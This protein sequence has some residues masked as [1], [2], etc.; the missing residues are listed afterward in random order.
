LRVAEQDARSDR[1]LAEVIAGSPVT[2][3]DR[4][5]LVVDERVA[6]LDR[7]RHA[8]L[9]IVAEHEVTDRVQSLLHLT[10]ALLAATV[11]VLAFDLGMGGWML[12][13]H[14]G[15]LM[16]PLSSVSF[17]FLMQIGILLGF[18]TGL[19]AVALLLKRGSNIAF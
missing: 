15:E 3:Q 9:E 10:A 8:P 6:A 14:F 18:L 12:L 11:T 13:L 2:G 4:H 16:P 19:P 7:G 1:V 17:L 5:D